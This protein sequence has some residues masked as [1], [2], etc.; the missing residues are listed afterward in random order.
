MSILALNLQVMGAHFEKAG[1]KTFAVYTIRVGDS[2]NR[3]WQVQR[4]LHSSALPQQMGVAVNA[5]ASFGI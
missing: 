4:R 2:D 3:T 1:S 5:A